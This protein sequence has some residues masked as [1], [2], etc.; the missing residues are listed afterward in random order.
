MTTHDFFT[1]YSTLDKTQAED[2]VANCSQWADHAFQNS[3]NQNRLLGNLLILE[4]YFHTMCHGAKA[5]E[6]EP[7]SI[8]RQSIDLLW[9]I[10]YERK[11]VSEIEDF[12]NDSYACVL[13][14]MVGEDM[15][16]QQAELYDAHFEN[17]GGSTLQ[18]QVMGWASQM[19]MEV[20]AIYGGRLDFEEFSSCETI[21]FA[22]LDEMLNFLSDA[23][24]DLTDVECP[25]DMAKDVI[26]AFQDM[27]ITPLFQFIACQ[28]QKSLQE[29][30]SATKADYEYLQQKY[31]EYVILPE[32]YAA[33]VYAF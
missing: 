22:E 26:A 16:D 32:E 9:D 33:D 19:L 28:I 10:L 25:S 8:I 2:W 20:T 12:V 11:T 15:T 23:C 29:A 21:D 6:E 24:M 5:T 14:Y 7:A 1:R 30:L 4:Q 17:L 3:S 27:Y 31:R 13:A 18:W